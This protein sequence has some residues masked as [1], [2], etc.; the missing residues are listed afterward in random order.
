[1]L[2]FLTVIGVSMAGMM[3]TF[4]AF[5]LVAGGEDTEE[6]A[7]RSGPRGVPTEQFFLNEPEGIASRTEAS[8]LERLSQVE[9]HVRLEH[10]AAEKFLEVP[11]AESLY[12]RPTSQLE[13]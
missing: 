13:D 3:L 4:V 6:Y 10:S 1:M 8:V 11:T 12:A 2:L 7:P 9:R 5:R